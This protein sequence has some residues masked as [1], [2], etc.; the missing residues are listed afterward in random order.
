[1]L[2]L[3]ILQAVFVYNSFKSY[4]VHLFKYTSDYSIVYADLIQD[5]AEHFTNYIFLTIALSFVLSFLITKKN[6][7]KLSFNYLF[8]ILSSKKTRA[9]PINPS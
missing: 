9:P 2:L 3:F 4:K 1:M 5:V 7:L 8:D 6:L